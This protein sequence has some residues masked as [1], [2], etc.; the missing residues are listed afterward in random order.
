M[1]T[2]SRISGDRRSPRHSVALALVTLAVC[3]ATAAAVPGMQ[4]KPQL[5]VEAERSPQ[6]A[7]LTFKGKGW[8]PNGRLKI[9]G[10]R[11]P[12]ARDPQDFG[13]YSV[14][15]TGAL[16]GRKVVACS[17]TS[18]EDGSNEPVTITATDSATSA[19][20]MTKVQGGAWVC[21]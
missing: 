12:G 6:G 8:T 14:D 7:R 11:P 19:K 1:S 2:K 16:Q 17:T 20:A 3:A 13:M 15:S 4:P 18:M 21:Q 5:S 9:T 10:T